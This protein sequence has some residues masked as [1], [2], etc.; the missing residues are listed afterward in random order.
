MF[1]GTFLSTPGNESS[2]FLAGMIRAMSDDLPL[3]AL[4]PQQSYFS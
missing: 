4:M 3:T 2:S 1:G